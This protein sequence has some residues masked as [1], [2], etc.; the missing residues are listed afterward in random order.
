[1][2][3]KLAKEVHLLVLPP[4]VATC[5]NISSSKVMPRHTITCLPAS[6][7][8]AQCRLVFIGEWSLISSDKDEYTFICV[9]GNND[10]VIS[11]TKI[12]GTGSMHITV[13]P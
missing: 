11:G 2:I 3:I 6:C 9:D 1:V 7:E 4:V 8:H 13:F 12:R 5:Q 10:Q